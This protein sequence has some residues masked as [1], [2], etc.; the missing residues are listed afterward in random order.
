MGKGLEGGGGQ[1]GPGGG[2]W[3]ENAGGGGGGIRQINVASL[4][5]ISRVASCNIPLSSHQYI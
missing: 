5:G 2:H 1:G 3:R 4:S